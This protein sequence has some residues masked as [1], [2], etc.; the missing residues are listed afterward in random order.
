MDM[1]DF[2]AL[3][4]CLTTGGGVIAE[5]CSCFDHNHD[6]SIDQDDVL[7]FVECATGPANIPGSVPP[8]CAP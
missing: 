4:K 6:N 1:T 8:T 5:G 2:A 7:S 3:Q